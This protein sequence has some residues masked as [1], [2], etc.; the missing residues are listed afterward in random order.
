MMKR[1]A[2]V[3]VA[4]VVAL[5]TTAA[6]A[7]AQT[8]QARRAATVSALLTF[9]GFF[10][11][12]PVV[13]RGNLA[14]RDQ[15]VLISASV[16]RAIP[17]IF[18]GPSPADGP[19]EVRASFWDVG[20]L[21]RDDPRIQS[22]G[23]GRLL[24][25]AAEGEWPRPGEV[26]ALVVTDAIPVKPEES[27]P[28]IRLIALEPSRYVGQ[29]VKVTG[30]FRGRNLYGEMPQAP[31]RSQWDFVLHAADAGVWVTGMRPRGKDLNL[32]IDKRVDTSRWLE[33][34]GVVREG[35]G[36]VWIEAQQFS[37]ATPDT[38]MRST[39]AAPAPVAGPPPVVIFSDPEEGETGV[40]LK[41][42]VRL[43][44]SRDMNP[45]SFKG[46]V[47]WHY[48]SVATP[49]QPPVEVTSERANATQ[50][51]YDGSKRSLEIR[52]NADEA[53]KYQD[54][55]VQLDEG[56]VATDGAKL[57]PWKLSFILGAQ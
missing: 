13:V 22:L 55:Y 39:E 37:T 33:V 48:Q 51:G 43:Q 20:R 3:I 52:I 25:N 32:D 50:V 12:Q 24:S 28:S 9:A 1:L 38:S 35:R 10:Q 18:N 19:V 7:S 49:G 4:V 44:F 53:A 31:G 56:I 30:Q 42:V 27:S 36:L 29:R 2:G 14:T 34:I 17:L 40:S 46:R 47:H 45:E 23:L 54:V 16:E 41:A 8:V 26:V 57:V 11:G 6:P 5:S 21:Q 15:A